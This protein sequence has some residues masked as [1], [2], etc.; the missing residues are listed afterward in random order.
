LDSVGAAEVSLQLPFAE[1]DRLTEALRRL[2]E[3][4]AASPAN[5]MIKDL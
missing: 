5:R 4:A 2:S 1:T 3:A